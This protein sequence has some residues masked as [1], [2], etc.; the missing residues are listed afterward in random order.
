MVELIRNTSN[1]T[2]LDN[3]AQRVVCDIQ[4]FSLNDTVLGPVKAWKGSTEEEY[5]SLLFNNGMLTLCISE[6]EMF[7][8]TE[9]IGVAMVTELREAVDVSKTNE[10]MGLKLTQLYTR[11]GKLEEDV[12]NIT[13]SDCLEVLGWEVKDGVKI[14]FDNFF[15]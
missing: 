14:F 4:E 12:K 2:E 15:G 8:G 5:F 6:R 7:L 10:G 3:L 1:A 9:P 11:G 13:L